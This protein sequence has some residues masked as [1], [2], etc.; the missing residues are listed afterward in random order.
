[1]KNMEQRIKELRRRRAE[2]EGGGGVERIE[3]QRK[4][5][6]LTARDR[7]TE[8]CDPNSFQESGLF[9]EHRS[10]LFGMEGKT[11][12]ADGVITGAGT[13][14]GR[15]VHLASQDFTVAGGSAGE[16]HSEKVAESMEQAIKTGTPFVFMNDS[17]GA[18]V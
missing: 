18:R 4:S 13:V 11:F 3:K 8:L 10:V 12:P 2:I 5:G 14:L 15:R 7:I 9:A 1:M 17:G 6:K 16:V